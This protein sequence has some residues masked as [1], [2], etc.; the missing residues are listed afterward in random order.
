MKLRY[1]LLPVL[2]VLLMSHNSFALDLTQ[3]VVYQGS[4]NNPQWRDDS[5][6]SVS[7]TWHTGR[8]VYGGNSGNA[9]E[10]NS[11]YVRGNS[12][13][14]LP[15]ENSWYL[16]V[17]GRIAFNGT[18]NKWNNSG[19]FI[20]T[21]NGNCPIV[22][23]ETVEVQSHAGN[24]SNTTQIYNYTIT[25]KYTGA[26]NGVPQVGFKVQSVSQ[27]VTYQFSVQ[28]WF[29]WQ[30]KSSAYD[31]TEVIKAINNV[32]TSINNIYNSLGDTNQKLDDM[33]DALDTLNQTQSQQQQEEQ[34]ATDNISNQSP[35][36]MGSDVENQQT[37][38]I[39][40]LFGSFLSA[41]TSVNAGSCVIQ[42]PFPSYA[43]GNWTMNICQYKDKAGNI[44]SL[45]A[46]ATLIL[47]Y[48]P[49]AW[50]LLGMIYNEIRSFTNG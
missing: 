33:L 39:I 20:Y 38:S 3:N 49:V 40:N 32:R 48:L 2:C 45:F 41:L 13:S 7:N 12:G 26:N 11:F 8:I 43:G 17:S 34:Q 16:Q 6:S 25:C 22:D 9:A 47:F 4:G 24:T 23:M 46:S 29:L 1:I 31:D 14:N 50:R 27:L 42:L 28:N 37:T 15:I 44:I 35:S 36:D 18:D 19:N 21:S 30:Y 5:T 10:F